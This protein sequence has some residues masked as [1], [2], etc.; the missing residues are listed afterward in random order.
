MVH[1]AVRISSSCN[2]CLCIAPT[3]NA[4]PVWRCRLRFFFF[5]RCASNRRMTSLSSKL[6]RFVQVVLEWLSLR[7]CLLGFHSQRVSIKMT[8]AS[9]NPRRRQCT[10]SALFSFLICVSF[11]ERGFTY[12]RYL[13]HV[14][15]LLQESNNRR[16]TMQSPT[17]EAALF[18]R[19]TPKAFLFSR[20]CIFSF[21]SPRREVDSLIP[22]MYIC[23]YECI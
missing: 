19:C 16:Q 7:N 15:R 17:S 21:C 13:K 10:P 4:T 1:D 18:R 22:A 3:L 9:G 14:N 11:F 20:L 12:L 23:I 6:F 5:F 8:Q 2:F